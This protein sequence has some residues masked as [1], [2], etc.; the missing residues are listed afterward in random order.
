MSLT[1]EQ[2]DQN[3]GLPV[4]KYLR[5]LFG[6][7]DTSKMIELIRIKN[8]EEE[9]KRALLTGVRHML[10]QMI[11]RGIKLSILSGGSG[12]VSR[13]T[14]EDL[15]GDYDKYFD[16]LYF[17]EDTEP[18]YKPDSRVFGHL[19]SNYQSMQ[20]FTDKMLYIG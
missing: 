8:Q 6:I 19:I 17:S 14:L 2:I 16:S 13:P 20:I 12:L 7:E 10:D 11:S 4:D 5:A 9:Y 1:T 18:Y 15:L 3:W